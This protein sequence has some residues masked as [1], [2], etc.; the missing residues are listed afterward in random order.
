MVPQSPHSGSASMLAVLAT[1]YNSAPSSS[2]MDERQ[3]CST[4]AVLWMILGPPGANVY[5][6]ADLGSFMDGFGPRQNFSNNKTAGPR[7]FYG[8][9]WA[10]HNKT[11][12]PQQFYGWFWA[13][14]VPCC[15]NC[16]PWQFYGWIWTL[17]TSAVLW[18]VLGP[19][20]LISLKLQTLALLW[21]I[22]A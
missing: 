1:F 17:Q 6:T 3:T 22:S 2:A 8:W 13:L 4:S 19:A 11:A 20:K 5:K 16:G 14:R 10:H 9:F 18:M 15:Q 12:G 21:T 7:Q